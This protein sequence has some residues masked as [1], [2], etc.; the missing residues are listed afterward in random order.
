MPVFGVGLQ[1]LYPHLAFAQSFLVSERVLIAT[2][3]LEILLSHM[4]ID[5]TH[6]VTSTLRG[7]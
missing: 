4:T 6:L 1:W 5:A 3:P 2:N 7:K